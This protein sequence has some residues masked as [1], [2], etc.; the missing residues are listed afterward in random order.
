[1]N[2][3]NVFPDRP[4]CEVRRSEKRIAGSCEMGRFGK[5]EGERSGGEETEVKCLVTETVTANL[6]FTS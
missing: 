3:L 5:G 1:M 2:G 6:G 4:C